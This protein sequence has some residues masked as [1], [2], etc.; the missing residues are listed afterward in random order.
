MKQSSFTILFFT[1]GIVFIILGKIGGIS[2]FY[3]ALVFKAMIMPVLMVYYHS[4]V[5]EKY[6]IFHRLMMFGFFFS[7]LGDLLLQFSKEG[8]EFFIS[9]EGLFILGIAGF[10]LAHLA[11][12]FAFNIPKGRNTLFSTRIY[13]LVLVLAYVGLLL[14]LLYNKLGEY[15]LPVI[16]YAVVIHVM[17]VS[18]LN[19]FGKVNGI[20]YMLV[21]IGALLF[22]ASDSMIAVN[23]FLEKFD[24]AHVLIMVTY[25]SAQYLIAIGALRQDSEIVNN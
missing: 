22:V 3:P 8:K 24:F 9:S 20:S 10:M 16:I 17:L 18:A 2:L 15:R 12:T 14:W 25:I 19:R 7:W 21:T 11:Y 6:N 4:Q 1:V 5:K 13:Q 23:R